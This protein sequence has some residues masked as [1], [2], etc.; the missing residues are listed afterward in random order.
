M[1][2]P[3][4]M[5]SSEPADRVQL[6]IKECMDRI[7]GLIGL[8]LAFP[9]L[10][11]SGLMIKLE[12]GGPVFFRQIRSGKNGR[13]FTMF[14]FRTM[15]AD[16]E[17]L[18][19]KLST[20][21]EMTGPVF[22]IRKDPRVTKVGGLLR[23]LSIDEIPQ[24]YNVLRGEMSLVGPRPPLPSEVLGYDRWQRRKLSVKPG[25]TCLWQ[26]NG[27]NAVDFEHWMKLDL[28]YIDNWSLW[29]DTKILVKTIPAVL[30]GDGAC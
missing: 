22:K 15:V 6:V 21:N 8:A 26:I 5:Y 7:G 25:L 17:T 20:K 19:E 18:K 14:K 23:K 29:L 16:A 1:N 12:D 2:L 13:P 4:V 9:V 30:R 24:F 10:L 3:A 11:I 27:R 28:E